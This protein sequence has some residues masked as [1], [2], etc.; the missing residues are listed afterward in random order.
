MFV[1]LSLR[2]FAAE[3]ARPTLQVVR[4]LTLVVDALMRT[5]VVAVEQAR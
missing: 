2:A 1:A 5:F 3:S 4:P